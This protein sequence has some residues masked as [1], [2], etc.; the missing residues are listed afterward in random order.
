[1]EYFKNLS[2]SSGRLHQNIFNYL[3]LT[4]IDYV[5]FVLSF[6]GNYYNSLIFSKCNIKSLHSL[7]L[8]AMRDGLYY[9]KNHV[10]YMY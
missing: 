10:E 3:S 9:Y 6:N 4:I 8:L 1:M 5:D 7:A 2:K